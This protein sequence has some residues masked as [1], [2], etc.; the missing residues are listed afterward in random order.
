MHTI[1]YAVPERC[2]GICSPKGAMIKRIQTSLCM[3]KQYLQK[4]TREGALRKLF[5]WTGRP[6]M[7]CNQLKVSLR[8]C[9]VAIHFTRA[10]QSGGHA[11]GAVG[12][13][14]SIPLSPTLL[15]LNMSETFAP[16]PPLRLQE[17]FPRC[18]LH[19]CL[20]VIG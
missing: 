4:D 6:V 19:R 14:S 8:R 5:L 10:E 1:T 16:P 9:R 11:G 2:K 15:F 17:S 12:L 3:K 20:L 7:K 13:S 18:L